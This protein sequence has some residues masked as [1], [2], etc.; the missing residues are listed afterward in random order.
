MLN[1]WRVSEDLSLKDFGGRLGMSVANLC[2]I[3]KGRKGV[4]PEKAEQIARAISVPPALLVR[5]SI[6]DT[7]ASGRAEVQGG[8]EAR[9][10]T[11]PRTS[12][13]PPCSRSRL[14]EQR[15][16]IGGALADAKLDDPEVGQVN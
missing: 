7:P 13:A 10:V 1:T 2:D 11:G 4:S 5:L 6:E 15:V 8:S 14:N 12:R 16:Q 3:E 9:C